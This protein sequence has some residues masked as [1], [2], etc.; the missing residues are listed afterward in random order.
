MLVSGSGQESR[1]KIQGPEPQLD[2]KDTV[3]KQNLFLAKVDTQKER[4]RNLIQARHGMYGFFVF[5]PQ[6]IAW[7][8]AFMVKVKEPY[9]EHNLS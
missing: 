7:H 3:F 9:Y 5:I 6:T 8:I 1:F 2:K 4:K